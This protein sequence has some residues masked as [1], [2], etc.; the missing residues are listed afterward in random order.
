[1]DKSQEMADVETA[2]EQ[3]N[4]LD[5]LTATALREQDG[6]VLRVRYGPI[7][8]DFRVVTRASTPANPVADATEMWRVAERLA[9]AT[10]RPAG[11]VRLIGVAA[12]GLIDRR[13]RVVQPDLFEGS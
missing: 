7:Q 2:V 3:L 12:S 5:G 8:T 1:M 6:D 11:A 9:F 4:R 10:A 13:A